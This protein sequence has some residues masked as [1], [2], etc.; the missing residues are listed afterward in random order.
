MYAEAFTMFAVAMVILTIAEMLIWPAISTL[1]NE[2]APQGRAGFYQGFINSVA[3]AGR[4]LGPFLGGLVVD[5]FNIQVLLY[6]LIV[7]LLIPFFTT[8]LYD[9]GIKPEQALKK[10]A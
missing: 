5:Y 8:K 7:M 9:R 1:A 10:E 6:G 3:A 4:M 2:L